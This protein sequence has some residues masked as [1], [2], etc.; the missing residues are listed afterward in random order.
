[1]DP[2][3]HESAAL[4]TAVFLNIIMSDFERKCGIL[5]TSCKSIVCHVYIIFR[6]GI[7][8]DLKL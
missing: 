3:S 6:N 5:H 4:K 2:D 7:A 8:S 1:M